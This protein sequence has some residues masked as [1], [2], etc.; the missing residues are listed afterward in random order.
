VNVVL[1]RYRAAYDRLDARS[2]KAVWPSVNEAALSKAFAGLTSQALRFESCGV[3]VRGG[4]ATATCRGLAR[5]VTR[6][7]IRDPRTERRIWSFTLEKRDAN[8]TISSAR[9]SSQEDE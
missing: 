7:G 6:M 9:A 8:W 1:Q 2:A 4:T 3:Q 5:Y